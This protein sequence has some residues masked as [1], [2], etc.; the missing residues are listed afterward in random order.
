MFFKSLFGQKNKEKR[1][2]KTFSGLTKANKK[3]LMPK[4]WWWPL[5]IFK[6]TAYAYQL[7]EVI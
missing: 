1:P 2:M 7:S 5:A 4:S 3:R 6:C